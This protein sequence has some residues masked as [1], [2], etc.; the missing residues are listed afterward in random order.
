METNFFSQLAGLDLQGDLILSI[1]KMEERKLTVSLYLRNDHCGDKARQIIPPFAATEAAEVLDKGFFATISAPFQATS[2]LM[3]NMEQYQK[4]Q[5]EAQAKS[6]A[7]KDK[8]GKDK[9]QADTKKSKLDEALEKAAKLESE[10]KY[11]EA[12]M[13]VPDPSDYP[14]QADMLRERRKELSEHFEPTLF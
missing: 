2:T 8:Q 9:K 7:Q 13:A 14:E 3:K 12:W 10:G 4:S 6:Q 5:E 1:R 11:R